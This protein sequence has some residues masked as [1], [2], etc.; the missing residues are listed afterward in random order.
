MNV[1]CLLCF[2]AFLAAVN[3]QAQQ[4]NTFSLEA[5][6]KHIVKKTF[7]IDLPS[8]WKETNESSDETPIY[9]SIDGADQLTVSIMQTKQGLS[10]EE[11]KETFRQLVE[12]RRKTENELSSG[13]TKLSDY[14]IKDDGDSLR[15]NFVG[16]EKAYD[17]RFI[18]LILCEHGKL[19]SFYLES[20]GTSDERLNSL[21]KSIFNSIVILESK[22]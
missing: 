21:A 1:K 6:M 20:S 12:T 14:Q 13:Q 9:E 7:T 18:N 3:I 8:D 4:T 10:H 19:I 17:R 16:F 15:T 11:L 2:I 5:K 22:S